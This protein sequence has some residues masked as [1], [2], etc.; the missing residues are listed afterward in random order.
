MRRMPSRLLKGRV[1]VPREGLGDV[2][3]PIWVDVSSV[4]E[5]EVGENFT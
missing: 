2:V 5:K 3:H 4:V 1:G